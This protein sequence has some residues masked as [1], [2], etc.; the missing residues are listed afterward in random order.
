MSK[1]YKLSLYAFVLDLNAF[2]GL[3]LKNNILKFFIFLSAHFTASIIFTFIIYK[4]LLPKKYKQNSPKFFLLIFI[5]LFTFF[6]PFLSYIAFFIF[7]I[8]LKKMKSKNISM[9]Y[10]ETEKLFFIDEIPKIQRFFGEG[11]VITYIYNKNLNP[12]MRLKAFLIISDIISPQ[13]IKFLKL[14]LSDT[15]DE[16]RLFSFSI[17]NRLEKKIQNEIF[18][19]SKELDNNK[20]NIDMRLKLAKLKW[21]LIYLN[22]VDEI[23]QNIIIEEILSLIKNIDLKEAKL[24]LIKVYLLKKDYKKVE[25]IL[26]T[27]EESIETVPYLL[28]INFYKKNYEMIVDLIKKYPE[29]KLI[30]KFYFI[31]RLWNDN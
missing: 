4:F 11:G 31:Y 13:T 10:L 20:N 3:M 23:F 22:L 15:L 9:N 24:L 28:E 5:F 21:E 2:I 17:I 8:L 18:L 12:N 6:I 25:E 27:L 14:G 30:E 29:I 26:N 7:F 1:Q 19:I 16:I